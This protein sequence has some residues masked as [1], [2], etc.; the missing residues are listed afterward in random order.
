MSKTQ[1]KIKNVKIL[2]DAF[3]AEQ[4]GGKACPHAA[5]LFGA[6]R[7]VDAQELKGKKFS[8]ATAG[9]RN[10]QLTKM[11]NRGQLGAGNEAAVR[12]EAARRWQCDYE[13]CELGYVKAIDPTKVR[14]AGGSSDHTANTDERLWARERLDR[15][16]KKLGLITTSAHIGEQRVLGSHLLSLVLVKQLSLTSAAKELGYDRRQLPLLKQ[17]LECLDGAAVVYGLAFDPKW[18]VEWFQKHS[19][20]ICPFS[21]TALQQQANL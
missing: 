20:V 17:F 2:Q 3:D 18:R 14:V 16:R 5:K 15:A 11:F 7:V 19:A 13:R 10:D 1:F 4:Q 8:T 6:V 12:Y 21:R 9:L